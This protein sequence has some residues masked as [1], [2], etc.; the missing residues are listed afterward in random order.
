MCSAEL[1]LQRAC[2]TGL[3][4][5][6]GLSLWRAIATLMCSRSTTNWM[7]SPLRR[8]LL[9]YYDFD[10]G[11]PAGGFSSHAIFGP[12]YQT[13]LG[14]PSPALRFA[15]GGPG[16]NPYVFTEGEETPCSRTTAGE[17]LLRVPDSSEE[18]L[19]SGLPI[20]VCFWNRADYG[21]NCDDS[22]G[23]VPL[24]VGAASCGQT[25]ANYYFLEG[26]VYFQCY[27]DG[28]SIENAPAEIY[29]VPDGNWHLYASVIGHD[30]VQ[31]YFDGMAKAMH[32]FD[33]PASSSMLAPGLGHIALGVSYWCDMFPPRV[34]HAYRGGFAMVGLWNRALSAAEILQLYNSGNGL[35]FSEL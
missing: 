19:L 31:H 30:G 26:S 11:T 3:G 13:T 12:I 10:S 32:A 7:T 28:G 9:A 33:S 29:G 20:T 21:D 24:Q 35:M 14:A 23:G 25:L 16:G 18:A 2:S 1:T 6:S 15:S 22:F 17:G 4:R 8:G 34:E 27:T 5:L